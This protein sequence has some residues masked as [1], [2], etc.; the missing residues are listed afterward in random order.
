M[1]G[2]HSETRTDSALG[3]LTE[4]SGDCVRPFVDQIGAI[5]RVYNSPI[6]ILFDSENVYLGSA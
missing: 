5:D 3:R 6:N 4:Y 2:E 1:L